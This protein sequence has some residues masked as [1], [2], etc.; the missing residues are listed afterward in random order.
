MRAVN[1]GRTP[2]LSGGEEFHPTNQDQN[3]NKKKIMVF[4]FHFT[5]QVRRFHP[6]RNEMLAIQM[7]SN[8]LESM[9]LEEFPPTWS[10][11]L[12]LEL[13]MSLSRNINPWNVPRGLLSSFRLLFARAKTE[14]HGVGSN[15][16]NPLRVGAARHD[17]RW[18]IIFMQNSTFP[19][20]PVGHAP[21]PGAQT[22]EFVTS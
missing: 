22:L 6:L 13:L 17:S 20:P 21:R 1:S 11:D 14:C 2:N 19:S 16:S 7:Y 15:K 10:I 4:H 5:V 3:A 8:R 18:R 12:R 9:M